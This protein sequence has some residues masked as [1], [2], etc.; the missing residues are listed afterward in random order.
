[1]TFA[2]GIK[3]LATMAELALP[4]I[5][6]Y[7]IDY[8]IRPLEGQTDVDTGAVARRIVIWSLL[9]MLC[10]LVAVAGNITANR[11]AA[12]VSKTV[13]GEIRSDL[14]KKTMSL[15]P[16][17][18]DFYTVASLESRLT[19]DTYNIHHFTVII[20]RYIFL[21]GIA[22]CNSPKTAFVISYHFALKIATKKTQ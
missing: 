12:K 3:S 6:S 22:H 19:T 10:A 1:M 21:N 15:S 5:L 8:V 20:V 17:Q 14:F 11:M 4:Y 7:I 18:T 9:M 13:A 16:A 2:F